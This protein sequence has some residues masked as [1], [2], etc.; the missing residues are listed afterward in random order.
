VTE[1]AKHFKKMAVLQKKEKIW[2]AIYVTSRSEKKVLE[3]LQEKGLEAYTP[4]QK[5]LRQW[6]DR[7][8]MV[9]IPLLNG[10]V[11]VKLNE[12]ER[13]KVFFVNGVVQYV[14]FNGADAVIREEEIQS[15]QN[16]VALGYDIEVDANKTFPMGSK[17]RIMQGPLKG[18]EGVVQAAENQDW[19]YVQLESIQYNLKVKLP[20]GILKSVQL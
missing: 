5:T 2:R 1:V 3:K 9:E 8:K 19:L 6:S 10:Y 20:A 16:I 12:Q 7:K 13:D 11:F 14:R 15:L 17:I 18:I 4:I